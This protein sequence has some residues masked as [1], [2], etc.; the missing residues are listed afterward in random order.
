MKNLSSNTPE[1]RSI[2]GNLPKPSKNL[3]L[4]S[5]T[6]EAYLQL[7]TSNYSCSYMQVYLSHMTEACWREKFQK[8]KQQNFFQRKAPYTSLI[9]NRFLFFVL[10][11]QKSFVWFLQ[12]KA[13]KYADISCFNAYIILKIHTFTYTLD[14]CKLT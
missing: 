9:L 10:A 5:W 7:I 3:K 12:Q 13:F 1:P 6:I 2:I 11:Q 8:M 14:Q 4:C